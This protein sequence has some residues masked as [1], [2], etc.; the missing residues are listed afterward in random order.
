[1]K[2]RF[3]FRRKR[4]GL[5]PRRASALRREPPTLIMGYARLEAGDIRRALLRLR[6]AWG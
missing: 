4:N 2:D 6:E 1:M 5:S 3:F